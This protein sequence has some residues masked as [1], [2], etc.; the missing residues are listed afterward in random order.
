MRLRT[1]ELHNWLC[2]RGKN[3][4]DLE[5]KA[6]A[7]VA[8]K[9]GDAER[10][11]WL[12]KSALLEAVHFAITGKLNA[13][14][15]MTADG[16]VSD[17]ETEGSVALTFDDGIRIER[18]RKKS[19]QF[20]LHTTDGRTL[21]KVAAQTLFDEMMG[22]THADIPATFY[23][24]QRQMARFV[25]AKPEDRMT[26]V[27]AWFRLGPLEAAE[28]MVRTEAASL[29][30]S[31]ETFRQRL[32]EARNVEKRETNDVDALTAQIEE[33]A[34]KLEEAKGRHARLL[35]LAQKNR[36]FQ[37]AIETKTNYEALQLAVRE[38]QENLDKIDGTKLVKSYEFVRKE[39]RS[40][41]D[42]LSS[43]RRDAENKHKL[44]SGQFDGNCPV[45][46]MPCPV[47]KEILSK[48]A[49]N[50]KHAKL[51]EDNF[52]KFSPV[53]QEIRARSL[54]VEAELQQFKRAEDRLDDAKQHVHRL[55]PAYEAALKAPPPID[56]EEMTQK[57]TR[58]TSAVADLTSQLDNLRR[59]LTLVREARAEQLHLATQIEALER[60]L[61]TQ[62]EAT[63]IFGRQGAQRRVAESALAKIQEGANAMLQECGIGLEVD[64]LW[65]REGSGLAKTCDTC[66]H[67]FPS[68]ERVKVCERCEADRGPLLVNKLELALSEQSGAAEDL[69]GA[70][71]QL[72]ASEWL[73]TS[74]G[75][76]W[77]V[78]LIDEPFGQLDAFHRRTFANHLA[79]MLGSRYG[80]QQALVIAH[81]SAVLDA[82][83]GRIEIV[84][85]GKRSTVRVA[86]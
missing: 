44:A 37:N 58:A 35:D 8:K 25:L 72:S 85:D 24:Q 45:A 41:Y 77:S 40:A 20:E 28:E 27:S 18:A 33:V 17:G 16:W 82:L 22:L 54:S 62:R 31:I 70:A 65:S 68:S 46:S 73:R 38:Q 81:H 34:T 15:H 78:A 39:E 74:R 53:Y 42:Q 3:K 59:S 11:N 26:L 13:D 57:L 86:A 55:Q 63:V 19:T 43:A 48:R 6:Y 60:K 30:W 1:I 49:H 84:N 66:G 75:S 71:I 9:V 50:E 4:L 79:S 76:R 52:Q 83:P 36:A 64:V 69:A 5:A 29:S 7:V 14:R 47:A 67:P 56:P 61:S 51:A 80:F 23:F 21:K 32:D 12:G 2:Y 10:S